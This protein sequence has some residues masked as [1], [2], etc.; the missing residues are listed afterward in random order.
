MKYYSI[1]IPTMWKSDLLLKM[2]P[3]Y[4]KSE[5]VKEVII[6]DNDPSVAPNLDGFSKVRSY[7]KGQ[8]IFVNPA[9]NWG[10]ELANYELI[11]ANDDIF[12]DSINIVLWTISTSDFDIVGTLL[13]ADNKGKRIDD[14]SYSQRFPANSFGCFMYVKNY[15]PVPDEIKLWYGDDLQFMSNKKKGR[16]VNFG[17]HS[18]GSTTINSNSKYFRY[19]IGRNDMKVV[20]EMKA[21]GEYIGKLLLP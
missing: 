20:A 17:I 1:V 10:A 16:L 5:F 18:S 9:W 6:I 21:R 2:L 14:I 11:L 4:E 8:N 13:R 7:T 15:V 19:T 12:I 3:E